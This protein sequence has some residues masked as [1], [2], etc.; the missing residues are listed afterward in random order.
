MESNKKKKLVLRSACKQL[1]SIQAPTIEQD[2]KNPRGV[3]VSDVLISWRILGSCSEVNTR[4]L[5]M[6]GV[7]GHVLIIYF[8]VHPSHTNNDTSL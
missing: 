6:A 8:Q 5:R 2:S 4:F 7:Y 1:N 3:S